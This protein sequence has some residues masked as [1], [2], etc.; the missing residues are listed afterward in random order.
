MPPGEPEG[1]TPLDPDEQDGLIPDHIHT[2]A[3]LNQWEALNISGGEEWALSQHS[4]DP[5]SVPWLRELHRRLFGETWQWAGAFRRSDKNISPYHWTDVPVLMRDLVE[6]I[7]TQHAASGRSAEALDEIAIRFHHQLV[8]IHPWANGNGRHARVATDILLRRWRRPV[9]SWGAG[10][11]L[12][13]AGTARA[14]YI[15]ALRAADGGQF[16]QLRDFVRS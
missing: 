10:A 14:R 5:L 4:A 1:N 3:E 12:I 6:N 9:F 11:D 13:A 16:E 2:K 8:R 15:S 7:R